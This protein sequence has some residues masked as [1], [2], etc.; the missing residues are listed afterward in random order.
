MGGE[1]ITDLNMTYIDVVTTLSE[2]NPGAL[3][4]CMDILANDS[5]ID[6][7]NFLGGVGTLLALDTHGVYGSNIWI[8]YKYV[9]KAN[10]VLMLA[11]LRAVQLGIMPEIQM[12]DAI[13]AQHGHTLDVEDILVKVKKQ[14]EEFDRNGEA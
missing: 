12:K 3:R 6:P 4:V 7:Q 10:L 5:K 13:K 11:V 2:G 14:L 8:L 9:C 1:R